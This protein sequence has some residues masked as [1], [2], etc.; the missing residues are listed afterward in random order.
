MKYSTENHAQWS[1]FSADRE[2]AHEIMTNLIMNDVALLFCSL[3][4][5][6]LLSK[7]VMVNC[8]YLREKQEENEKTNGNLQKTER[9]KGKVIVFLDIQINPHEKGGDSRKR[10]R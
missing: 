1:E 6:T 2:L 8:G 9:H 10:R 3:L 4:P 5:I 7:H